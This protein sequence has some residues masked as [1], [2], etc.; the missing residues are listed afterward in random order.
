MFRLCSEIYKRAGIDMAT[1]GPYQ[2]LIARMDR[3]L[4]EIMALKPGLAEAKSLVPQAPSAV[5][6]PKALVA[7]RRALG[8]IGVSCHD[9]ASRPIIRRGVRALSSLPDCRSL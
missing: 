1:P 6:Q 2:A 7:K 3:I 8:E 9:R 5:L 4:D